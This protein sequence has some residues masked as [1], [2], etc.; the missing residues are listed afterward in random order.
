MDHRLRASYLDS[1]NDD[2]LSEHISRYA[3]R[4]GTEEI[5]TF[6]DWYSENVGEDSLE[7]LRPVRMVLVGLGVDDRTERMVKFLAENSGLNIS[8]LTFYCFIHEGKTLLARQVLVE[9]NESPPSRGKPRFSREERWNAVVDRA[10]GFGVGELL[11]EITQ[12]FEERW[13]GPPLNI[14]RTRI[15]FRLRGLMRSGRRGTRS[16]ARV[17]PEESWMRVVFYGSAVEL[18]PDHFREAIKDVPF[19]T[20][21]RGREN[22]PSSPGLR[23]N[24]D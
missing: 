23:S 9:G 7:S 16:Y 22:N 6:R 3:G 19:D 1:M 15:G 14:G 21:P 18:C 8:L 4:H 2:A 10:T 13:H 24:L 11:S 17:D 12:L 5:V 20:Y